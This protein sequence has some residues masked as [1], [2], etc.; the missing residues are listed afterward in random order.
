MSYWCQSRCYFVQFVQIILGKKKNVIQVLIAQ[1]KNLP[2]LQVFISVS[3]HEKQFAEL[4]C[5]ELK[6]SVFR[7]KRAKFCHSSSQWG[8]TYSLSSTHLLEA[9]KSWAIQLSIRCFTTAQTGEV[10]HSSMHE[11]QQEGS[12]CEM[13]GKGWLQIITMSAL[14]EQKKV[15]EGPMK[16]LNFFQYMFQHQWGIQGVKNNIFTR[17]TFL[18]EVKIKSHFSFHLSFCIA[19]LPHAM[20]WYRMH[21]HAGKIC[22]TGMSTE[23]LLVSKKYKGTSPTFSMGLEKPCEQEPRS[24]PSVSDLSTSH[25]AFRCCLWNDSPEL[26]CHHHPIENC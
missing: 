1:R 8:V 9:I 7:N 6:T 26:L 15:K 23:M 22:S 10:Q 13:S 16:E 11:V 17:K 25:L 5:V 19:K 14:P 18:Q 24:L 21:T 20:S 2:S 12:H 4:K 3:F